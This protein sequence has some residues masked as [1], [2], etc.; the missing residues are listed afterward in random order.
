MNNY[1]EYLKY[2]IKHEKLKKCKLAKNSSLQRG[3]VY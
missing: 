2:K 3:G 1:Y